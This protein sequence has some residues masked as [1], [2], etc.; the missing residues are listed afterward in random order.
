MFFAFSYAWVVDWYIILRL[1]QFALVF[2][3][4][5]FFSCARG[6][7]AS[8]EARA[9]VG[10][11]KPRYLGYGQCTAWHGMLRHIERRIRPTFAIYVCEH[12]Q[13]IEE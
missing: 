11:G 4:S 10:W 8:W 2:M 6:R 3:F 5:I 9:N 7:L 12:D 1:I 13:T